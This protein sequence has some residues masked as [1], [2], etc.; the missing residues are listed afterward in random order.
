MYRFFMSL[1]QPDGSF[2]VA[3][4]SEVD[5]RGIYCLLCVAITLNIVTPELI[6]GTPEFILSL[7]TY[8]GGFAS[9]SHPYFS[10]LPKSLETLL[11]SPR[12]PLGEA[13]GGYTYCAVASWVMLRPFLPKNSKL[14]IN[15]NTLT[16][17]L[18]NMQGSE[19]ELGGFRGRT[20]KLVDACYSWWVAGCFPLLRSLGVR[21]KGPLIPPLDKLEEANESDDQW[22]DVDGK[23]S[24]FG[25]PHLIQLYCI[26]DS[27]FN[28]KALQEYI[29]YAAQHSAG[30]LRDKP[31]K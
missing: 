12:P 29:L 22:T 28:R 4:H 7:Q 30:G 15:L 8:E 6:A 1:K 19:I 13:H 10:A 17:W 21:M 23:D 16:R 14:T 9:S 18:V 26:P 20:N 11:D 24:G 27:L 31:P 5:V 3:E 25:H 2:L